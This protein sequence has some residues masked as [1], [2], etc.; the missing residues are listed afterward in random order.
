LNYLAPDPVEVS[1]WTI[2]A[3]F[4]KSAGEHRGGLSEPEVD[5]MGISLSAPGNAPS[6][7]SGSKEDQQAAVDARLKMVGGRTTDKKRDF[8]KGS[9]ANQKEGKGF[10]P[11]R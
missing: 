6:I 9:G 3:N 1:F 2:S 8:Y 10:P 5:R 7:P 11:T 4:F